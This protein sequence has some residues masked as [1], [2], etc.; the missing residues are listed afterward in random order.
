MS[1]P[2][3][4]EFFR[5]FNIHISEKVLERL[6]TEEAGE[7]ILKAVEYMYVGLEVFLTF[8]PKEKR[9][10]YYV[11]VSLAEIAAEAAYIDVFHKNDLHDLNDGPSTTKHGAA[12]AAWVNRH[13]PIQVTGDFE[14]DS[15]AF[16]NAFVALV[17]G[18][19]LMWNEEGRVVT[20]LAEIVAEDKRI[21]SLIYDLMWR[22]PDYRQIT[23]IFSLFK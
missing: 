6:D 13:H 19:S 5:R 18:L 23:T 10:Y 21:G 2:D 7:Y 14:D 8:V 1:G 17:S 22:C 16:T 3:E 4:N 12:L 15:L 9:D 20:D 11:N